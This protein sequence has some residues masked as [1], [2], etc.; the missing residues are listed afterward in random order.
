MEV[1]EVHGRFVVRGTITSTHRLTVSD[2]VLVFK[3]LDRGDVGRH[4]TNFFLF[5]VVFNVP[6]VK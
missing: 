2:M 4:S 6:V 1:F 5:F 3:N